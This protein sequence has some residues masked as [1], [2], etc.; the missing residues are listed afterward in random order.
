LRRD[1][2]GGADAIWPGPGAH[3]RPP[4]LKQAAPRGPAVLQ[5]QETL[6]RT[7]GKYSG[8]VSRYL[9]KQ[10]TLRKDIESQASGKVAP[11]ICRERVAPIECCTR[12]A[13]ERQRT[14][15]GPR[16]PHTNHQISKNVWAMPLLSLAFGGRVHRWL[17]IK[18]SIKHTVNNT[19]GTFFLLTRN[20]R[21]PTSFSA[22][23]F[24]GPHVQ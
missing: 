2:H 23:G 11:G 13:R 1:A 6:L 17:I 21:K 24:P 8:Y 9:S 20:P 5:G 19:T 16:R 12:N 15:R 22:T 4:P 3:E 7:K 10:E 18:V 14:I